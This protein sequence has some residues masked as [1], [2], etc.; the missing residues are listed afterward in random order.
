MPAARWPLPGVSRRAL[1]SDAW[2]PEG[3]TLERNREELAQ[4]ERLFRRGQSFTY[5][6]VDPAGERVLGSIYVNRGIGGPD[7]AVFFW[8]R[9]DIGSPGL[10]EGLKRAVR[11]WMELDWPFG[12]VVFPGRDGG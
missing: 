3:F 4:K 9:S 7:A 12:W 6:V 5:T 2:P 8:V 10:E 11:S 1:L